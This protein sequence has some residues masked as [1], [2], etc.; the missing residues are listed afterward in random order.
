MKKISILIIGF[1]FKVMKWAKFCTTIVSKTLSIII[2][3]HIKTFFIHLINI[4]YLN[5]IGDIMRIIFGL[6]LIFIF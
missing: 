6:Y 4:Q 3:S 5:N 2:K 1:Q